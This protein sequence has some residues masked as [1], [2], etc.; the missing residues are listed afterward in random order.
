MRNTLRALKAKIEETGGE[1]VLVL[2]SGR[3]VD[4]VET[5]TDVT[6]DLVIAE[7]GEE[8]PPR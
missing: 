2:P 5:A 8:R 4:L 1:A 6:I 3:R 7:L